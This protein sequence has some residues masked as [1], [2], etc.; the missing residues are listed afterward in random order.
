MKRSQTSR[1][2]SGFTLIEL[3]VVISII[4]ILAGLLLPTLAGAS[5][6]A[7]IKKA[8]VDIANLVSAVNAYNATYSRMPSSKKTRAAISEAYPDFTYGTEQGG[9]GINVW[10]PKKVSIN[11]AT[12]KNPNGTVWNISNAEVMAI[13]TGNALGD[14]PAGAPAYA[15]QLD[16]G[17]PPQFINFNNN[18]NQKRT[19]FLNV[20][21]ARGTG[22]NG[23]SELDRV[24]RDPWGNP[25]IIWMDLDYDNRVLDPF[26]APGRTGPVLPANNPNARFVSQPVLVMSLGPDGLWESNQPSNAKGNNF[27]NIYSWR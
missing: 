1:P 3:L 7:K 8:E 12:V 11:T 17:T 27:D 15:T 16:S 22:P 20:K 26:P 6:K 5:K 23:M 24:L 19:V 25:Y 10:N 13:L 14:F 21:T 9:A 2:Q 18:L 4:A